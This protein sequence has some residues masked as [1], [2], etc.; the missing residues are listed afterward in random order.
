M[1]KQDKDKERSSAMLLAR[2][3]LMFKE[4]EELKKTVKELENVIADIVD[5][6]DKQGMKGI[7]QSN[8]KG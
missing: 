3:E 5:I 8:A 2:L 4:H 6:Q 1:N 7:I